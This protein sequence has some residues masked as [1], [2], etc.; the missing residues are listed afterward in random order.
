[1][2]SGYLFRRGIL[3]EKGALVVRTWA[4]KATYLRVGYTMENILATNT[5]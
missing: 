3:G 5:T 4:G 2:L 1:M